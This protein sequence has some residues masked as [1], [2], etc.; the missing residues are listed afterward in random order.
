LGQ[1]EG[2]CQCR[3]K[4]GIFRLNFGFGNYKEGFGA[5]GVT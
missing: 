2:A 4:T 3:L 5:R 1:L